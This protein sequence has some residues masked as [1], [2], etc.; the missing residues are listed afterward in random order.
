M[1]NSAA[2]QQRNLSLGRQPT[3]G[4]NGWD[5]RVARQH[6]HLK[7]RLLRQGGK[8]V[9]RQPCADEVR[10]RQRIGGQR[11]EII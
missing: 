9:L 4:I 5:H 6:H 11:R 10:C 2:Y 3:G 1:A 7:R 8:I